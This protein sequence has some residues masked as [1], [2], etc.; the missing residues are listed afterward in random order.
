MIGPTKRILCANLNKDFCELI[1]TVLDPHEVVHVESVDDA[2][3]RAAA[4]K[5]D[6]YILNHHLLDG[7]G[8]RL[9]LLLRTLDPQAR[10]L[11]VS[12][13]KSLTESQAQN[14][15]AMGLLRL[16]DDAFV[17]DFRVAVAG[18]IGV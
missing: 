8:I 7:T 13:G 1:A 9:A 16:E 14:V 17:D 11:F 3:C 6:L 2:L 10:I 18:S 5:F 12:A 4:N 15:G